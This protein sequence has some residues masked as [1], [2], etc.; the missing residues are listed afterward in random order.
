MTFWKRNAHFHFLEN[1]FT[2]L[3]YFSTE[4]LK[5]GEQQVCVLPTYV[6]LSPLTPELPP[7][8]VLPAPG[9]AP[10]PSAAPP[11]C[12]PTF[13]WLLSAPLVLWHF[14]LVLCPSSPWCS[15]AIT[16]LGCNLPL[17][18]FPLCPG[19][20]SGPILEVGEPGLQRWDVVREQGGLC[21]KLYL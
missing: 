17:V 5:C 8:L 15:P 12:Y 3:F 13:P 11:L 9:A 10:S 1:I 14:L 18:V 19:P 16:P 20:L 2:Y 7:P 6:V 21:C 4:W